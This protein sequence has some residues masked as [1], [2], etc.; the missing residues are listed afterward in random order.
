MITREINDSLR[1]EKS[2][3]DVASGLGRV[4]MGY[5]V[6]VF[7]IVTASV[8]L[9]SALQPLLSTPP[10]RMTIEHTWLFYGGLAISKITGLAAWGLIIA[11]QWRCLMSSSERNGAKWIIFMCMTCVVMSPVLHML[12]VF[13]GMST[14][15]RWFA[16]PAAMQ[17]LKLKFTVAGTYIMAASL[18]SAVLYKLSFW[19]YLQTVAACVGATK[20]RIFVFMFMV[21]TFSMIGFTAY[22]IFGGLHPN[23]VTQYAPFVAGGWVLLSLYW[24]A[25]ILVVKIAIEQTVSLV[26]D[27]LRQ[28]QMSMAGS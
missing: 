24:V 8:L 9:Y 7:G 27:P 13:G 6:L 23:R 4:L 3:N 2:W 10:K 18:I 26:Y 14:P 19:Y 1:A 15:V 20:A 12:A 22:W 11:G 5:A 21:L 17:G 28:P 25:M 16:G